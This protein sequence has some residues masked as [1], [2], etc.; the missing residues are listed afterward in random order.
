MQEIIRFEHTNYLWGLLALLP[1]ILLLVIAIWKQKKS[2]KKFGESNLVRNSL[3]DIAKNKPVVKFIFR[4]IALIFLILGIANLQLGSKLEKVKRSGIDLMIAIDVSKSMLAEDIKPSRM[5]SAKQFVSRLIDRM[6][7][8][9]I[10]LIIFAGNA[11]LQMPLTIDYASAKMFLKTI[12]TNM[13][14][15]Q[16]TAIG[17]AIRLARES[18]DA[19][20]N[21][22]KALI[23]IS[24][25]EDHEEGTLDLAKE[26]NEEGGKIYTIGIGSAKGAPIPIYRGSTQVDFKRDQEKNVVLSKLNEVMLQQLA[27]AADGKYIRLTG[28]PNELDY[29]AKELASI[30]KKDFEERVFTDYDDKFQYFLAIALLFLVIEQLISYRKNK[31]FHNIQLFKTKEAA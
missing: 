23:V 21:K 13:V 26:F 30:E 27:V 24:D 15:T 10:G 14:P 2:L 18:F 25:G 28:S 16:G 19:S 12:N 20:Q 7:N 3:V 22:H 29:L 1:L 9:R 31:W 17:E 4:S 11:Y 6:Q 8:D 5:E